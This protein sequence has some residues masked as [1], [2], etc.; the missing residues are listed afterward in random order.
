MQMDRE[1][2]VAVLSCGHRARSVVR[3]LLKDSNNNVKV[4]SVFDPDDAI[5]KE[6]VGIWEIDEPFYAPDYE[7]AINFP[8][9]EWV[10]VFSPNCFHKEQVLAAFAAGKHVFSEK[11]LATSISGTTSEKFPFSSSAAIIIPCDSMPQIF[12]GARLVTN[13]TFLPTISSG[14]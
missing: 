5:A 14:L 1:I 13:T 7:S 8:G 4:V 11:P 6:T 9:V 12:L 10:M 2:K 3:N